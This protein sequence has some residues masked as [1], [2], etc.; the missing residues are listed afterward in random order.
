MMMAEP[1]Q[2][3][4]FSLSS[5]TMILLVPTIADV[6]RTCVRIAV[7]FLLYSAA[8]AQHHQLPFDHITTRDGLSQDI[9]TC[10]AQ[11]AKGFMWFG[12]EDGLNRYDGYSIRVYKSNP[13]DSTTLAWNSVNAMLVGREGRLW[14]SASGVNLYDERTDRF[15]RFV[16]SPTNPFSLPN[17]HVTAF[18]QDSTG[19]LWA[20][21]DEGIA[22]LDLPSRRWTRYRHNPNDAATLGSNL[23]LSLMTD[24]SGTLWVGT[25]DGLDRFDA[26]SGR[27]TRFLTTGHPTEGRS[28]NAVVSIFEDVGGTLWLGTNGG[29]L[30]RFDPHTGAA[31][32]YLSTPHSPNTVGH[33]VIFAVTAG[34]SGRLWIGHFAGLDVFD[35]STETIE[36]YAQSPGDPEGISGERVYA[37]YPDKDG[38]MWLGSYHGGIE[39]YDPHRHKFSLFRSV[40]VAG[41]TRSDGNIYAIVEDSQRRIWVG[42]QT[43]LAVLEPVYSAYGPELHPTSLAPP[44][45]NGAIIALFEDSY[46]NI[47][48][49]H[50]KPGILER[51]NERGEITGRYPYPGVQTIAEDETGQL[52][53]GT[54]E[55]GI[56][57][58]SPKDGTTTRYTNKPENP[59]SLWGD[60]S[61]CLFADGRGGV[62]LGSNTGYECVNRFDLVTRRFV[63]YR[64][65]A[66]DTNSMPAADVRAIYQDPSGVLW[67]G[68][69][70]S[71]LTKYE[72]SLNRFTRY[73]DTEGLPSN[74]VKGILAD[75]HQR[76]WIST[77]RGL[78]RFDPKTGT[79]RN[80]TVEDGLQ[81]DRFWSG[82]ALR[83]RN[84]FMYFGGNQGLNVFHPD[85][86]R[87]D[88]A[89]PVVRLTNFKV[90]DKPLL[91][92]DA[93]WNIRSLELSYRQD[94]LSFEFVALDYSSPDRNT[95]AYMLEG[96]D[97]GWIYAGSRRY[98]AYTHL[99]GGTY[100]FRVKAANG[101]GV[102]NNEGTAIRIVIQPPFWEMWWFRIVALLMTAALL[103][104]A[105]RIRLS[106]MLAEERLRQR[107]AQDL[108][109]DV[110]TNLSTIALASR[111]LSHKRGSGKEATEALERIGAVAQRTTDQMKDIVWVLKTNNDSLDNIVAKMREVAA[112]LLVGIRYKFEA[113][114][115][116]LL[117]KV[118]LEFKRNIF[119]F[120][121]ECL[122]NVAKHSGASHVTIRVAV[123]NGT[124]LIDIEDN[125]KGFEE[126][127]A[128]SGSGLQ[129]LRAR[130]ELLGGNATIT[131]E[132]GR[133]THVLL[134]VKMTQMR[135]SFRRKEGLP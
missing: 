36:H 100:T 48:I 110:G 66:A 98:A 61:R 82:S 39:R 125:G 11:D 62:W 87:D 122:N 68:F 58:Y 15:I 115:E 133:G 99:P 73:F 9:I 84:G 113:S 91:L 51:A 130:A 63:H 78:S 116:G 64:Y 120:Y 93:I 49:G 80:Y 121:K 37:I 25:Q 57:C 24:R 33:N 119:L 71:G 23:A 5:A 88:R 76:L 118:N 105:Y 18:S 12:T 60:G 21:T 14:V 67:F 114:V 124:L 45:G 128:S 40:P 126:H 96:I 52:W 6:R 123:A 22:R 77:E 81:G 42:T 16:N 94:F 54:L 135:H 10:I 103:Y 97:R 1:C 117:E 83:T 112:Q 43:G 107:I 29:G 27:S 55:E 134:T 30:I 132:P 50:E 70:G 13:P 26:A 8:V 75:D 41:S 53:F 79:F 131:S 92:P 38:A 101:D 129:N 74:Y 32:R 86:V 106:R 28:R 4:G 35:P 85:S 108:H 47:W 109:D 19:A 111:S 31:K 59:D 69:W 46:H 44:V 34:P 3:H 65:N 95:Y 56:I 7:P 2:P 90:F 17:N 72:P 127:G 104:L 20:A 89:P 102:W